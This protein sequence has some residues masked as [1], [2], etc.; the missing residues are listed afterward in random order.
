M[1][2]IDLTRARELADRLDALADRSPV[3]NDEDDEDKVCA[4]ALRTL[5]DEVERLQAAQAVPTG[6][7]KDHTYYVSRWGGNCRDCA[8]ENGVCPNS[9]LPCGDA[10]KAI[11]HVL[12]ALEYGVKHGYISNPLAAS[13][14][15]TQPAPAEGEREADPPQ[16]AAWGVKLE[17]G[18]HE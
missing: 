13:P 16:A 1:T 6:F 3:G 8:D 17:G 11:E 12:K 4:A 10:S 14:S 7:T 15:A 18:N 9:G 2:T 5:A